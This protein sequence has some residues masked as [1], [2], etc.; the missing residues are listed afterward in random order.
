M[1]TF[2]K[3]AGVWRVQVRRKGQTFSRTFRLKADAEAWAREAEDNIARGKPAIAASVSHETTLAELIDIHI[4][5]M[6]EVGKAS[7]RSKAYTLDKL[8]A[9]FGS[10]SLPQITRERLIEF[11]KARSAQG[12]TSPGMTRDHEPLSPLRGFGNA[13][14]G[15]EPIAGSRADVNARS[16]ITAL[17]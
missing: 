15:W 11:A 7:L 3:R 16:A 5:D 13:F 6:C 8:K 9:T 12:R 1:P 4:R 14:L 10:T 17:S 2:T